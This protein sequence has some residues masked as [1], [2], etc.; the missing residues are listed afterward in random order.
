MTRDRYIVERGGVPYD[1]RG[2]LRREWCKLL[3]TPMTEKFKW[4][5]GY[6]N[7]TTYYT[8]DT[9]VREFKRSGLDGGVLIKTDESF[10]NWQTC[11]TI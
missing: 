3:G 6:M 2:Y 1:E 9:A 7:A 10:S 4:T 5:N 11:Y 8:E